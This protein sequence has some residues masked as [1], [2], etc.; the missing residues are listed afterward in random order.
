LVKSLAV[1]NLERNRCMEA[2][3]DNF[4]RHLL[5]RNQA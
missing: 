2:I 3:D 5:K 4:G 1:L